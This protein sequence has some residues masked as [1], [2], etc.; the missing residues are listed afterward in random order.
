MSD[1]LGSW[2]T[3]QPRMLLVLAC[4]AGV[5]GCYRTA[6]L[7]Q[8]VP[9]PGTRIV[10]GLTP[11]GAERMESLIGMDA[12]G[13]EAW[14]TEIRPEGWELSLLRVD[15]WRMPSTR[16]NEERVVFPAEVLRG[17]RTRELDA[18]RTGAF[19]VGIG[20][21]LVVLARGFMSA[22]IDG[23]LPPPGPDPVH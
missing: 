4:L 23:D 21:V 11:T 9:E 22:W 18:V 15:H 2:L 12:V 3:T 19:A 5:T 1:S 6:E 7:A 17:V 20:T 13:V 16:W 8:P 14:V 10:A